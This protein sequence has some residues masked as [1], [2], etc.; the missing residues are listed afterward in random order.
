MKRLVAYIKKLLRPQSNAT[1]SYMFPLFL[2]ISALLGAQA[3][4][5]SDKS[6]LRL[7]PSQNLVMK[8]DSFY[9]DVY[10][11]AHVPVNAVDVEISFSSDKVAVESVDKGKSVLTIWAEEPSVKNGKIYFSGG[12]YQKGFI[13]EHII[14]TIKVV[15][16]FSGETKFS[17]A[18]V[19]LLAGDGQGSTVATKNKSEFTKSFYIYDES[20]DPSEIR[21]KVAVS[22]SADIDGD[23]KV[24]MRDISS[25]MATWHKKDKTYD[26]NNDGRMNFIDFSIIL[27]KSFLGL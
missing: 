27:A 24:S 13:G 2:G 25:F 14:A 12:T 26:F 21:A 11:Y 18:D 17:V 8:G 6:Y 20:D 1:V 9:I 19:S 5:S 10:A 7:I 22:I 15:A 16:K 4:T 3:I 23:G